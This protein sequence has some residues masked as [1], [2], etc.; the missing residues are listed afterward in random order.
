M[1]YRTTFWVPQ[2]S[3]GRCISTTSPSAGLQASRYGSVLSSSLH[4]VRDTPGPTQL[5][6]NSGVA[7]LHYTSLPELS[8]YDVD[9]TNKCKQLQQV[10]VPW[11]WQVQLIPV[12]RLL[13]PVTAVAG[14]FADSHRCPCP[15]ESTGVIHAANMDVILYLCVI[16]CSVPSMATSVP[17]RLRRLLCRVATHWS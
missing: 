4:A 11:P 8:V 2:H 12:S 9:V 16:C 14:H 10:M 5:L 7:L 6:T 15:S 1:L 3:S 17:L 13:G